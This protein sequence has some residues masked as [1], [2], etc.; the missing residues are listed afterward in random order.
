MIHHLQIEEPLAPPCQAA[1]PIHQGIREYL[2]SIA[3]GDFD[4]AIEKIRETNPLPA[5]CGGICAHHCEDE[6]RRNDV[7]KPLS[8][9]GLKRFAVENNNYE[10]PQAPKAN[11]AKKVAVIGGGPSG[12]T[13]AW[14]L[15]L[16]GCQVTVFEKEDS[17]GGAVRHY[18]PLYRL[19]DEEIDRDTDMISKKG[20]I[21]YKTGA[22]LGK[23]FTIDDLKKEG[24]KAI[25][26][27]TGLPLSRSIPIPGAE[28]KKTLKALPF[29]QAV[30]RENFKFEGAPTVIVIGGG[31]VAMDVARSAVRCGAGKVKLAC[32]ESEPEMPAFTWEIEEAREEGVE[33]FCS[34]G[35]AAVIEDGDK[36]KGLKIKEC[37][38]VFDDQGRFSPQFNEDCVN[39]IEGDIVIFAIGQGADPESVKNQIA[40]DERG[41]VVFNR[42]NY[43][44]SEEG[45]FTCGEVAEGPGTA[46]QSMASGRKAAL[47]IA[48]YIEGKAFTVASVK[49]MQTTDNLDEEV[50]GKVRKSERQ[51]M[52][53]SP[54]A[55]RK[56]NFKHIETCFSRKQALD[57]AKRCLGC[58]AGAS[59]IDDLCANCLTC[60]RVCPYGVPVIDN[61]GVIAIR[62]DQC[63]ACGLCMGICPAVAIEFRSDY[64]E[65]AASQ[66][67]DAVKAAV[68][69]KEGKESLLVLSC[70]YGDYS[71]SDFMESYVQKQNP[72]V[73]VVRFPCISKI[74]TLHILKAFEAGID[75][76]LVAG[77]NEEETES[78]PFHD[79]GFWGE[80]RASRAGV[81]LK[82]LGIAPERVIYK[83]LKTEEIAGFDKVVAD[84]LSELESALTGA[85]E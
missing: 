22:T 44:T 29:L 68:E 26:L 27:A 39:D 79:S 28:H 64:I 23:D 81:V 47:S 84:T 66:I 19:P 18:I 59:R 36:I 71:M 76:V 45:V 73:A 25:L 63:Q 33:I 38:C 2:F 17:M 53:L 52:V 42:N 3:T 6:C 37:T 41:N 74:D 62:K 65:K 20:G 30:K 60:L 77:C 57:E 67:E 1:C 70:A 85:A 21:E 55:E 69:S 72:G 13:A 46:V 83:S 15:A 12:L 51:E 48:A 10:L 35:P 16:Q 14:D 9:R 50:A 5:I 11:K 49:E 8:I 82:E 56:T 80:K 40:L 31:N 24:Y 78:C 32:L 58:L 54:A 43:Q 7:D 4:K 75:A 61:E 34:S